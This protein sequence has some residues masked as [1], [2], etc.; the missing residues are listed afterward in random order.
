MEGL[1]CLR[2]AFID[3]LHIVAVR[4]KHPGC[5]IARIVF[6]TS[7]RWPR[8]AF[9]LLGLLK[10]VSELCFLVHPVPPRIFVHQTRA[11]PRIA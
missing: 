2:L 10:S 11:S 5:I 7:L 1:D 6:E 4:I 8:Y 9:P 3:G